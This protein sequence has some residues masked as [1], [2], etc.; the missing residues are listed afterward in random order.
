[1]DVDAQASLPAAVDLRQWRPAGQVR[2]PT[3]SNETLLLFRRVG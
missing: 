2:R 3:D 1:V